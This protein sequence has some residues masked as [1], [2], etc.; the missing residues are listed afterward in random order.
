MINSYIYNGK[1]KVLKGLSSIFN[2]LSLEEAWERRGWQRKTSLFI[3][4]TSVLFELLF[5]S[6]LSF[7]FTKD[8]YFFFLYT[9]IYCCSSTV[10]LIFPQSLPSAPPIPT[11]HP[12]SYLPL[13]LSMGPLYMFLNGTSP[14]FPRTYII[15]I[16]NKENNSSLKKQVIE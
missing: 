3:P 1:E 14:S 8:M 13:P 10:V 4:Y 5:L 7:F 15:F 12:Q 16:H 9:Y 2:N 6:F 11:S